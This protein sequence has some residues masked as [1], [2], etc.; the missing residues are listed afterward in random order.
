MAVISFLLYGSMAMAPWLHGHGTCL[1]PGGFHEPSPHV[2][3]TA[4]V[5]TDTYIFAV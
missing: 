4:F 5:S 2:Q 3:H 1:Q